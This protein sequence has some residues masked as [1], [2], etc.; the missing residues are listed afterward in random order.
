MVWWRS[1]WFPDKRYIV[2]IYIFKEI[3]NINKALIDLYVI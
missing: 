3:L 1:D 2:K